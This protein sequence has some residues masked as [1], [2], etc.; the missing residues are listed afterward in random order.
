MNLE[1]RY[2]SLY[3]SISDKSQIH[4]RMFTLSQN[5]TQPLF[6]PLPTNQVNPHSDGEAKDDVKGFLGRFFKQGS[7]L[8]VRALG[9][10][11]DVVE[12]GGL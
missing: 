4:V 1:E 7:E 12:L 6:N 2:S 10:E 11:V 8:V 9:H 3:F 5:S